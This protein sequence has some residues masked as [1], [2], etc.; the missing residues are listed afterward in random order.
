MLGNNV[1]ASDTFGKKL[2]IATT[3]CKSQRK[4]SILETLERFWKTP[5]SKM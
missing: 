3:A 1:G 2:L 4:C 5:E